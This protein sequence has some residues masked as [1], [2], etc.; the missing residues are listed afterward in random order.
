M[1]GC[2]LMAP[3]PP[4]GLMG[5]GLSLAVWNPSAVWEIGAIE[6]AGERYATPKTIRAALFSE[7]M[8]PALARSEEH[9]SEL[10]SLMRNPYAVFC[11]KTKT[12]STIP[13]QD[14]DFR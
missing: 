10:P 5:P 6:V 12:T 3:V 4:S 7:T 8:Q 14:S 11:L 13:T 1:S 2:V 9:T